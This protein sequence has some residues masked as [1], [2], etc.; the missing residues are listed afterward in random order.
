MNASLSMTDAARGRGDIDRLP[1]NRAAENPSA[2]GW[3]AEQATK[4]A[5]ELDGWSRCTIVEMLSKAVVPLSDRTASILL[6]HQIVSAPSDGH[7]LRDSRHR[8]QLT[9]FG[10]HVAN[11]VLD[12]IGPWGF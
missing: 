11:A 2:A 6:R 12:E 8:F 3:G 9:A 1:R 5:R 4:V 10:R 7:R